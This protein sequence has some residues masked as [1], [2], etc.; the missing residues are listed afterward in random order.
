MLARRIVQAAAEAHRARHQQ[1]PS[2]RRRAACRSYQ[3][4]AASAWRSAVKNGAPRENACNIKC[5]SHIS[6]A[7][8][9]HDGVLAK[10]KI[11]TSSITSSITSDVLHSKSCG[12]VD[13]KIGGANSPEKR[14]M[15]TTCV[16]AGGLVLDHAGAF[17]VQRMTAAC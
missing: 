7:S 6:S 5:L 14:L 16:C 1:R 2:R 12:G 11:S 4:G 15:R 17:A 10:R 8:R 13:A 3:N 9:R